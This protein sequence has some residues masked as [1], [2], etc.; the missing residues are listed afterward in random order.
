MIVSPDG[1]KIFGQDY[2][3]MEF[4]TAGKHSKLIVCDGGIANSLE[5]TARKI[6]VYFEKMCLLIVFCFI[7]SI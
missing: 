5:Y 3:I 1:T 7:K 4:E 6:M 2:R